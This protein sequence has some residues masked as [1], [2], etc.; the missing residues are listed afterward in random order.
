MQQ[1]L[2]MR[3][4]FHQNLAMVAITLPPSES[5]LIYEAIDKLDSAVVAKA[6][7]ASQR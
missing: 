5:F 1:V 7:L 3:R 4:Q 2:A 6:E